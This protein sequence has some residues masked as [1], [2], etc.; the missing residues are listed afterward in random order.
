LL[1]PDENT[2]RIHQIPNS[3]TLS[4]KL[5]VAQHLKLEPLL[6]AF[7]HPTDGLGGANGHGTLLHDNL[8]RLR[9]LRN[10]SSTQLAILNVGGSSRPNPHGFG[11]GVDGDEDDVGGFDFGVNVGGEKEVTAAAFV[12]YGGEAGFID[13][14]VGGVPGVDLFLG[15]VDYADSNLWERV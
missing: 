8:I 7:Q 2:I 4:Q 9:Y 13:W 14:K 11:G 1:S 3:G 6:I 12:N 15:E 5:G 10:L